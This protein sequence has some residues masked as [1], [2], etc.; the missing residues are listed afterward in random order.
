MS[1]QY[2]RT[3]PLI[4]AILLL[5]GLVNYFLL[6]IAK[7]AIDYFSLEEIRLP[8]TLAIVTFILF[9]Y[10]QY[11]WKW[12]PLGWLVKVPNVNGRYKGNIDFVW[13]NTPDKKECTVEIVQ[14]AS[15]IKVSTY[16]NNGDK[17]K[18]SSKSV[19]EAIQKEDD[20][21]YTIYFFYHNGGTKG[22][23]K[24]DS[25][26]G[27]TV[28]KYLPAEKNKPAQLTGHYFTNRKTQTRG[29]I[30]AYFKSKKIKGKF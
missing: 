21:F 10:N 6:H 4:I 20:G 7:P 18:T 11:I 14:T 28:L 23:G 5:T 8:S 19:V 1:F 15:S 17:E 24:L 2:Y 13:A 22:D 27:A 9:L 12:A 30:K 29:E 3:K 26:E 16:Y 25:H